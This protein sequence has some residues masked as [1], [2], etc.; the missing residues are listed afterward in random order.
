[1]K[2]GKIIV[3]LYLCIQ[4]LPIE[5]TP[6]SDIIIVRYTISINNC[7]LSISWINGK[8]FNGSTFFMNHYLHFCCT[9]IHNLMKANTSR[10]FTWMYARSKTELQTPL[11]LQRKKK[12]GEKNPES[13]WIPLSV[14]LFISGH[15]ARHIKILF[16]QWHTPISLLLSRSIEN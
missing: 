1:M 16:C 13:R 5:N 3:L 15:D 7:V 2:T 12:N 4:R 9:F 11:N 6:Q 14:T 8:Y 10:P